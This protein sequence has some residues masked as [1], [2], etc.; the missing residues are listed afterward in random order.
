MRLQGKKMT[1]SHFWLICAP[2]GSEGPKS[3]PEEP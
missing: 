1:F 2:I 3:E